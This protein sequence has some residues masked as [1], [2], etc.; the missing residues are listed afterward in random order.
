MKVAEIVERLINPGT[1]STVRKPYPSGAEFSHGNREM[2]RTGD[3]WVIDRDTGQ[4]YASGLPN[5]A[6]AE[7]W[8][9][10]QN[11]SC[12]TAEEAW[13][14]ASADPVVTAYCREHPDLVLV[15]RIQG[16]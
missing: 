10:E 3:W 13:R 1:P 8:C 14:V 4:R 6:A 9:L 2:D 7:E 12:L 16:A 5:R 11:V 15:S